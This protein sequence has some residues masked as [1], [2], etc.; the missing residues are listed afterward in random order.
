MDPSQAFRSFQ[1]QKKLERWVFI[2]GLCYLAGTADV[3]L[4]L[5]FFLILLI[6]TVFTT[7]RSASMSDEN[8]HVAIHCSNCD[9]TD[10]VVLSGVTRDMVEMYCGLIDGTSPMYKF[11]P[12][13]HSSTQIGK[14]LTCKQMFRARIVE[15]K[16]LPAD[17]QK[18]VRG[19]IGN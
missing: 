9:K 17:W 10:Y 1:R 7:D 8:F 16:D 4:E 14:C 15:E 11:P 13:Q 3:I 2:I 12:T 5:R 19:R 18:D 6:L